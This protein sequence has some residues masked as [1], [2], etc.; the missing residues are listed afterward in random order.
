[1]HNVTIQLTDEQHAAVTTIGKKL[2]LDDA[3]A[4]KVLAFYTINSD[5][6]DLGTLLEYLQPVIE[7]VEAG[8]ARTEG[9]E[10][11]LCGCLYAA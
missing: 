6:N 11:S 7:A 2:R 5:F 9:S 3:S 10:P 4:L 1:M 8:R